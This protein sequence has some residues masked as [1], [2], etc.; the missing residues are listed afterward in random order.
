MKMKKKPKNPVL[1]CDDKV[2]CLAFVQNDGD[3][4]CTKPKL[5]EAMIVRRQ[6]HHM[7]CPTKQIKMDRTKP[8]RQ[9][10]GKSDTPQKRR[11]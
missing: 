1:F 9:R 8:L 10:G 11:K 2:T 3:V 4:I 5:H 7:Q 6:V